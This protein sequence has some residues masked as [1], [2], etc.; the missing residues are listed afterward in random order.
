MTGYHPLLF[1]IYFN[2]IG[3][4]IENSSIIMYANDTVLFLP[5]NSIKE[6]EEELTNDVT[7]LVDLFEENELIIN[8]KQGKSE[9]MLFG[10]PQKLWR[11]QC[12]AKI[13]RKL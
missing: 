11:L 8:L 5:C 1:L 2:D 6:I 7:L 13:M 4:C 12:C 9:V 10:T 3:D